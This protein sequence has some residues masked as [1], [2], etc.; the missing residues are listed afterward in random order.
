MG[1]VELTRW[2]CYFLPLPFPQPQKAG[3]FG[4]EYFPRGESKGPGTRREK[5]FPIATA[6]ARNGRILGRR[7]GVTVHKRVKTQGRGG[8]RERYATA[9][10]VSEGK[11]AKARDGLAERRLGELLVAM[12]PAKGIERVSRGESGR[13]DRRLPIVTNGTP[14][15]SSLG[16]TKRESVP[17]VCGGRPVRAARSDYP[18]RTTGTVAGFVT[19]MAEKTLDRGAGRG[20]LGTV[21]L[22]KGFFMRC[23]RNASDAGAGNGPESN[24]CSVSPSGASVW[25]AQHGTNHPTMAT[26]RSRGGRV[27]AG[28]G[29]LSYDTP[30]GA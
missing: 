4:G 10:V 5:G 16:V 22:D 3:V 27:L 7:A 13:F 28:R 26:G 17:G 23:K 30:G 14:T 24:L 20:K 21:K 1:P 25:R 11:K 15:L 12:D 6:R 29:G 9:G 18:T 2:A 8:D 19:N